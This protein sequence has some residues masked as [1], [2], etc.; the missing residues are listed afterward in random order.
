MKNNIYEKMLEPIATRM[1][2]ML[3]GAVLGGYFTDTSTLQ[4]LGTAISAIIL[5]GADLLLGRFIK[6]SRPQN[7]GR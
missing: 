1:G 4:E 7:I 6:K 2:T 3:A 5:I